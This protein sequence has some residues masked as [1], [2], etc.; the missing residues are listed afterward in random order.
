MPA[1][2]SCKFREYMFMTRLSPASISRLMI[3]RKK[4]YQDKKASCKTDRILQTLLL[5]YLQKQAAEFA[6][7]VLLSD[8]YGTPKAEPCLALQLQLKPRVCQV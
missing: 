4:K 3:Q 2:T 8:R 7:I 6:P 1:I 5:R